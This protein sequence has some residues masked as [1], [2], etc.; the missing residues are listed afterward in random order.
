MSKFNFKNERMHWLP[1]KIA[2]FMALLSFDWRIA[3]LAI[4]LF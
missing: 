2:I 3:L 1:V 4:F